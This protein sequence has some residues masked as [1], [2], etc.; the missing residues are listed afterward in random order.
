MIRNVFGTCSYVR[1]FSTTIVKQEREIFVRDEKKSVNVGTLGSTLHGKTQ[2]S[3][4]CT[5]VLNKRYGVPIKEMSE[6]DNS[7]PEKKMG[8]SISPTHLELWDNEFRYNLTDMPGNISYQRNALTNLQGLDAALFV[9]NPEEGI[10]KDFVEMFRICQHLN[11]TSI[12]V[13]SKRSSTDDES[14]ELVTMDLDEVGFNESPV[15]LEPLEK[16]DQ[17]S[18]SIQALFTQINQRLKSKDPTRDLDS[19]FYFPAEQ[20]GQIPKRGTFCAGRVKSGKCKV[21]TVLHAFLHGQKSHGSV[22]DMEIFRK[23]TDLL[24]AGDRGGFFIKFKD[25]IDFKRGGVLYEAGGE[26]TIADKWRVELKPIEGQL[27][28]KS[29]M[30]FMFYHSTFSDGKVTLDECDL[31][32]SEFKETTLNIT[33]PIMANPLDSFIIKSNKVTF[34]GNLL[35]PV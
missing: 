20:V 26:K 24:Q 19:K 6:I 21:G 33:S 13:I 30:E 23:K 9:I 28:V 31:D 4:S 8:S 29:K 7:A 14:V 18:L 12:P 3:S 27:S 10:L 2:L 25:D 16:L 5:K 1:R 34:I 15:V 11:I 22:K 17:H 32:E 35:N